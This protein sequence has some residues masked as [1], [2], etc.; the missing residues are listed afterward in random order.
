MKFKFLY[1]LFAI[2]SATIAQYPTFY[3]LKPIVGT[4][5]EFSATSLSS[6]H[7]AIIEHS[8]SSMYFG[9]QNYGVLQLKNGVWRQHALSDWYGF[10]FA[11]GLIETKSGD[12]WVGGYSKSPYWKQIK[13]NTYITHDVSCQYHKP[14]QAAVIEDTVYTISCLNQDPNQPSVTIFNGTSWD[15]ILANEIEGSYFFNGI[16][17]TKKHNQSTIIAISDYSFYSYQN[18]K[19]IMDTMYT[20]FRP[21]NLF[22]SKNDSII[23]AFGETLPYHKM[24]VKSFNPSTLELRDTLQILH[25]RNIDKL[26]FDSKDRIWYTNGGKIGYYDGTIHISAS[27]GQINDGAVL[28]ICVD[29]NDDMWYGTYNQGFYTT[30]NNILTSSAPAESNLQYSYIDGFLHFKDVENKIISI[31]NINGQT[32]LSFQAADVETIIDTNNYTK[33]IYIAT[34]TAAIGSVKSLKFIVE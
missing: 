3:K 28:S 11:S 7:N 30:S 24:I 13:G 10:G 1:L 15:S 26:L 21:I 17:K 32:L 14:Y 5:N 33:G 25:N 8:D 23:I 6:G 34:V 18:G 20:D 16:I 4:I 19:F 27:G 2:N 29:K 31:L 12:V 9:T 22:K